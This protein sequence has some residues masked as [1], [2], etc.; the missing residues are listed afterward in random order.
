MRNLILMFLLTLSALKADVSA[1]HVSSGFPAPET[2]LVESIVKEGFKRARI[3]IEYQTVP[4]ERSLI[5]V[6]LG[7]DDVEA[8]RIEGMEKLY[9]NLVRIPIPIH[10]IDIV[11][12]SKKRIH[13]KNISD[14]KP[15]HI[16]L[17]RGVKI[18]E[19][20][21]KQ[22][23]PKSI[24][25]ATSYPMLMKML[26][27]NRIDVIITSKVAIFTVLADT[28]EKGLFMTS[29]PLVSR[30]IYTYVNKKHQE[31]I[32]KLKTAY[33]SM[34]TDGTIQK[35]HEQFLQELGKKIGNKV[36]VVND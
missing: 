21:A 16:G 32:P 18:A 36:E 31:I 24:T 33:K 17:N 22:A 8:G 12:L 6:N 20:I 19:T 15:Y 10:N 30:P 14:L 34:E 13:I 11:L 2:F 4:P 27:N 7:F 9:P 26:S 1:L 25:Q 5:N 29:E 23:N 28:K 35:L 3:P